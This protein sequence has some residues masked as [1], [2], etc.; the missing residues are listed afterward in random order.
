MLDYIL[1]NAWS[2]VVLY[3]VFALFAVLFMSAIKYI[4]VKACASKGK[5]F[6]KKKYGFVFAVS[7]FII[8]CGLSF[9]F[10][11]VHNDGLQN[12][13]RL[14]AYTDLCGTMTGGIYSLLAQPVRKVL[15]KVFTAI[16]RL[17]RKG[18]DNITA[19]DVVQEFGTATD[20]PIDEFYNTIKRVTKK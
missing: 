16:L 12:V 18:K 14:V 7:A 13:G 10:Q 20:N 1:N 11:V 9:A 2:E 6:D 8:A 5:V 17:S 15:V 3:I 19:D 4:C